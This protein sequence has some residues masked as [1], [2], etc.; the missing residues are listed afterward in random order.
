MDMSTTME[1]IETIYLEYQSLTVVILVSTFGPM[2]VVKVKRLQISIAVLILLMLHNLLHMLAITITVNLHLGIV[3]PLQH[4]ISMT[5]FG[6][7]QDVWT[8]V[9]MIL[10][11]LGSIVSR[12]RPYKMILKFEYVQLML[13]SVDPL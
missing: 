9:V 2:L 1:L 12:I 13:S 7:E 11:S 10:L 4:T 8:I 6:M 5:L 3:P